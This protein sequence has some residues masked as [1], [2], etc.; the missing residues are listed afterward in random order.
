VVVAREDG[1]PDGLTLD[2]TGALWVALWAGGAV[3]RY[4]ASGRL[5]A[6]IELPMPKVTACT[7]GG[8]NLDEL[9]ITTSRHGEA[10][11]HPSA[12]ALFC[13]RPGVTGLPASTFA[14]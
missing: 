3:R 2:A 12:R 5:E 14:G 1:S 11:P 4:S 13:V 10:D 8:A 7:F 9:Y 6:V